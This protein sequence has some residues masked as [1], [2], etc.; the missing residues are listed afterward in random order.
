MRHTWLVCS[1][2]SLCLLVGMSSE[3]GLVSIR[4][5]AVIQ[6]ELWGL[7]SGSV[8]ATNV[9]GSFGQVL[10]PFESST[11]LSVYRG[12]DRHPL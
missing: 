6:R 3:R 8:S 5:E 11:V 10:C 2:F 7:C 1:E 12:Y 9:M 4:S